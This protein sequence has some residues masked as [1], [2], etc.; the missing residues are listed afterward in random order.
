MQVA[1]DSLFSFEGARTSLPAHFLPTTGQRLYLAVERVAPAPYVESML[2]QYALARGDLDGAKTF[3][4]RLPPSPLRDEMLGRIA[5]TRGDVSA[6][7][8][9]FLQAGDVDAIQREV[10]RLTLV[11]PDEAYQ[12]EKAL[13]D[14]LQTLTT[15]PDLVAEANWHLGVL[16]TLQAET[17]SPKRR[18]WLQRGMRD[19]GR[20]LALSPLSEK[21][22]LS[23]GTQ[24]L[25][26][27][28]PASAKHYFMRAIDLDPGSADAYAGAGL[29]DERLGDRASAQREAARSRALDPHS[30]F[31]RKL[32]RAIQ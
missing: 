28:D 1:S 3:A 29:A 23:A 2:A 7:R 30:S 16:A 8:R 17:R 12:L 31:L 4:K 25:R 21:Y 26:V 32:E 22:I 6:A 13:R 24:A 5:A 19:Y 9:A 10:D 20:A 15:H 11:R 14:R 27:H 18:Y